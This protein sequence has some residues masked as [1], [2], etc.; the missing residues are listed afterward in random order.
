MN[1]IVIKLPEPNQKKNNYAKKRR[2]IEVE[3]KNMKKL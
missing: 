3:L 1:I 2:T